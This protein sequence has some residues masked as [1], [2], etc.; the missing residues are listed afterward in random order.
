M[1]ALAREK[2]VEEGGEIEFGKFYSK[3]TYVESEIDQP[4]KKEE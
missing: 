1:E 2:V 3:P 4:P